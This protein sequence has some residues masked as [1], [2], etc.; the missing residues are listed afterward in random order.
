MTEREARHIKHRVR[1]LPIAFEKTRQKLRDL[2]DEAR[3]Y[4]MHEL[5]ALERLK[6]KKILSNPHVVNRAWEREAETAKAAVR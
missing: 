1:Y 6:T 5:M 2:E 4:G 3:R